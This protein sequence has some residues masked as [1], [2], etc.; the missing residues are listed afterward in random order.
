[1]I[2]PEKLDSVYDFM[3]K[4]VQAGR[5]CYIVYPLIS[6]SQKIDLQAAEEGYKILSGTVF[7]DMKVALLHSKTPKKDKDVIMEAFKKAEIDI[8]V[9]TTVIEVGVNV[10][11]ATVMLIENAERFGLTQLHQ[12]RGRVGRGS[13]KSY[14]IFVARQKTE[15]GLL[16]LRILEKTGDGFIIS[17]ED[18]KM[19]GPGDY[20]SSRQHG[21]TGFMMADIV[22]DGPILKKARS[23]AFNLIHEDE[24]LLKKE[25]HALK[26]YFMKHFKDK[27]H[28]AGIS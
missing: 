13:E 9:S 27:M 16:R 22:N 19:R 14:C 18:L 21:E 1:K 11:N 25:N 7:S 2:F 4:E 15:L 20:F 23:A 3:R 10:P 26:K 24:Q 17:E 12:L 6:E 5:Q 8:L 28:Y